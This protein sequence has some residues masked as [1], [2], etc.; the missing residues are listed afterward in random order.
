[1]KI[2]SL[3]LAFVFNGFTISQTD[4]QGFRIL[5]NELVFCLLI[6]MNFRY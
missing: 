6:R 3:I 1:M 2:L 4:G 5:G